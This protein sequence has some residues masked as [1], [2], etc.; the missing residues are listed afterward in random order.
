MKYLAILAGAVLLIISVWLIIGRHQG[1]GDPTPAGRV[2]LEN[3]VPLEKLD[4]SNLRDSLAVQKGA[5]A[6]VHASRNR[7]QAAECV[8][9]L[10]TLCD[11]LVD[12]HWNTASPE[13]LTAWDHLRGYPEVEGALAAL[14]PK[15]IARWTRSG[16]VNSLESLVKI[17][18]Q[19]NRTGDRVKTALDTMA[20]VP[21]RG[22]QDS[23]PA[24]L[25]VASLRA[26]ELGRAK[27]YL[28]AVVWDSTAPESEKS[29]HG[30][31][32]RAV[33]DAL[34][35]QSGT[36]DMASVVLHWNE[37]KKEGASKD[38]LCREAVVGLL[39]NIGTA[40]VR[41]LA[42][43][44]DG[45]QLAQLVKQSATQ[46][47]AAVYWA[48]V[49]RELQDS[50][51]DSASVKTGLLAPTLKAYSLAFERSNLESETWITLAHRDAEQKKRQ[52][53][54]RVQC[55]DW[56]RRALAAAPSDDLKVDII[57]ELKKAYSDLHEYKT[58]HEVVNEALASVSDPDKRGS[59]QS[60][61][62]DLEQ[63]E[64][65]EG[66][67]VQE[68][69]QKIEQSRL[70]GQLAYMKE[71]LQEARKSG[72]PADDINS[73]ESMVKDLELKCAASK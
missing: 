20:Q 63:E 3:G 33:D 55:L 13:I 16:T 69:T 31:V 44:E 14:E 70:S 40:Q 46:A 57:R 34:R 50:S 66:R 52:L 30:W 27:G 32:S 10:N 62:K 19:A 73:L 4:S 11:S 38:P 54:Q 35:A 22:Y 29:L 45:G 36:P 42:L 28:A 71:R 49:I 17:S 15:M 24:L 6:L 18:I 5:H 26:K 56:M 68:T 43:S 25:V 58:G 61:V 41:S 48:S 53:H 65:S 23:R 2:V 8:G 59:L 64:L 60:L 72:K 12:P 51:T 47:E 67:R 7:S 9:Y 21:I 1:G 39:L 37:A